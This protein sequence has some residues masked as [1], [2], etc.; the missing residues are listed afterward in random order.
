MVGMTAKYRLTK[1][2]TFL[3]YYG[4]RGGKMLGTVACQMRF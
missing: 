4:R 2:D 3:L 1:I